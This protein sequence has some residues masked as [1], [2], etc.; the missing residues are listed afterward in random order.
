MPYHLL[1]GATGLLGTYLLRDILRAGR[2]VAVVVRPGR[3]ETARQ[4]IE[5][6]LAA[7]EQGLGRVLPRVPVL[8]GDIC[9]PRLGLDSAGLDWVAGHCDSVIHNA[10]SLSFEADEKTGEPHRSNVEGTR[11]VLEL[12]QLT[13]I[14]K[15][16]HVS[17][18]YVCGLRMGRI[19][20]DELD[21][22]QQSGNAYEKSKIEAEKLVRGAPFLDA[23]TFYRPAIIIGDS[24]TGYTTTYHGFY[25]PLKVLQS[26]A[27]R[28]QFTKIDASPMLAVLGLTGNDRKNFVPVDWVSE[29]ITHLSG[30]PQHWGRTYHLTPN[31]PVSVEET[32]KAVEIAIQEFVDADQGQKAELPEWDELEQ[33]VIGQ[34]ETY[35]AYWRDDPEF[36][37]RNTR[38]AAPHLECP[39]VDL[40]MLLRTSRYALKSNF[41]WP[42]PQPLI[43]EFDVLEHLQGVLPVHWR[44]GRDRQGLARVAMQVN[45]PGGGQWTLVAD[46]GRPMA[47]ECGLAD[48]YQA[49]VYLNSNTFHRCVRGDLSVQQAYQQGQLVTEGNQFSESAILEILGGAF[50]GSGVLQT[51]S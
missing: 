29:V 6:I 2:Q 38:A 51:A 4:R 44:N 37:C 8:E 19:L 50:A 5:T 11:N 30:Q 32:C 15:F 26:L 43:P 24:R 23:P 9:A 39:D 49:L 20:E 13:G 18:A 35:R 3:M 21:V 1:T 22:G 16:H 41:G 31:R 47:A 33:I 36:D 45:G 34:M 12:C 17:T 40:A 14:R 25:T 48:K 27:S 10:A 28:M 42:R 46:G 7:W